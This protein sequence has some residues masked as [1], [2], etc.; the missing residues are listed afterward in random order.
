MLFGEN[1]T[2]KSSIVNAIEFLF[3]KEVSSLKGSADIKHDSVIPFYGNKTS[4]LSVEIKFEK[5]NI[6]ASAYDEPSNNLTAR[7]TI[8]NYSYPPSLIRFMNSLRNGQNILNRKKLLTYVD[9]Q[10]KQRYIGIGK[11]FGFKYLDKLEDIFRKTDNKI[12]DQEL[13][14]KIEYINSI[15]KLA[16]ILEIS[17]INHSQSQSKKIKLNNYEKTKEKYEECISKLNLIIDGQ[18]P[19]INDETNFKEYLH[20]IQKTLEKNN[21]KEVLNILKVINELDYLESLDENLNNIKKEYERLYLNNSKTSSLLL[22]ILKDSKDYLDISKSDKCPVCNSDIEP[23]K[24]I[25]DLN[26]NINSLETNLQESEQLKEKANELLKGI[27]SLYQSLNLIRQQLEM[28]KEDPN[29]ENIGSAEIKDE[30]NK[31]KKNSAEIKE[32]PNKENI[33]SIDNCLSLLKEVSNNIELMIQFKII[34]HDVNNPISQINDTI[35]EIKH[36]LFIKYINKNNKFENTLNLLNQSIIQLSHMEQLRNSIISI[37]NQLKYS[38]K[39]YEIYKREKIEYINSILECLTEKIN[40]YYN[41]IHDDESINSPRVVVS[42]STGLKLKIKSFDENRDPREYSS[43]GH[44]DTLGLCIFLAFMK[45]NPNVPIIILDD[46]VATVDL[47]H[48][49]RIARLLINEFEDYQLII[50]THNKMWFNQIK[51]LTRI[52]ERKDKKNKKGSFLNVEITDWSLEEGAHLANNKSDEENINKH[53]RDNDLPAAAH[54]TRRYLENILKNICIANGARLPLKEKPYSLLEYLNGAKYSIEHLTENTEAEKFYE[55]LI[56]EVET[57]R[58]LGNY[59]VHDNE[60]S[61]DLSTN[62]AKTFR[63][64]VFEL[65]KGVTCEECGSYM[66][67]NKKVKK[68]FCTNQNCHARFDLD[69]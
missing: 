1:G 55:K 45:V 59:L 64:A 53:L 11:L 61:Q 40:E 33:D 47:S 8:N 52:K 20:E 21:K 5:P 10:P 4:D 25:L 38:S 62:E 57:T 3:T 36:E 63:D 37:E 30:S 28:I 48:K 16:R 26:N 67:F 14:K 43:E 13:N 22:N 68:A 44:L 12:R 41:F 66:Q 34:A 18:F 60:E 7:R 69:F 39:T 42:G 65:H 58:Y 50:T 32:D 31:E 24:I 23:E 54:A 46:V 35:G 51:E 17:Q 6:K 29:K 19:L 15:N 49:E 56:D 9:S 27:E 2:G